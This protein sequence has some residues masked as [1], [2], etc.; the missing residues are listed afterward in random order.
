MEGCGKQRRVFRGFEFC[1]KIQ[2]SRII[3]HW[4]RRC[5]YAAFPRNG[6][7][8]NTEIP[9]LNGFRLRL[10]VYT[11]LC[12][13]TF[14][15]RTFGESPVSRYHPTHPFCCILFGRAEFALRSLVAVAW[16]DASKPCT[17][18]SSA[19]RGDTV[20]RRVQYRSRRSTRLQGAATPNT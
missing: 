17:E 9:F 12:A 7:G 19:L 15:L 6:A 20:P 11:S 14:V 4:K 10:P 5:K 16:S 8:A 3:V 1:P 2:L 18:R 13:V